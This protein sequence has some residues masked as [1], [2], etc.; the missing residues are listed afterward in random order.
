MAADTNQ[1]VARRKYYEIMQYKMKRNIFLRETGL[2]I[3]PLLFWLGVRPDGLIY[4]EEYNDDPGLLEIKCPSNRRNSSPADLL[5]DH[6]FYL[7]RNKHGEILLKR[8]HHF[9]YYTQVQMTMR[10]FKVNYCDFVVFIF[11]CMIKTRLEF[12]NVPP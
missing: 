2:N 12:D 8:D 5:S 9:D 7:Q 11:T 3:Q 10:L 1:P 4:D 6:Y